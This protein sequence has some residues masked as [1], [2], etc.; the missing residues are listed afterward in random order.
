[1]GTTN[2][3]KGNACA[4]DES[5]YIE[6]ILSGCTKPKPVCRMVEQDISKR[7]GTRSEISKAIA[8]LG[9]HDK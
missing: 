6:H 4:A 2:T 1:M 5:E 8:L 9:S 3:N 7:T